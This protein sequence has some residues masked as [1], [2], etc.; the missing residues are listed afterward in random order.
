MVWKQSKSAEEKKVKVSN[1]TEPTVDE[2]SPDGDKAVQVTATVVD[3]V[4]TITD[5]TELKTEPV[6]AH[7]TDDADLADLLPRKRQRINNV[8]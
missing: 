4:T 5:V 3:G 7:E 2:A 8:G 6:F 1:T